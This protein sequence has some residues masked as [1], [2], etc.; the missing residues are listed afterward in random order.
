MLQ[1][2]IVYW[3][4]LG[5]VDVIGLFADALCASLSIFS[6]VALCY[7]ACEWYTCIFSHMYWDDFGLKCE[8]LDLNKFLY[9]KVAHIGVVLFV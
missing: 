9:M 5:V 3:C 8:E 6:L 2:I 7:L 1:L 4:C